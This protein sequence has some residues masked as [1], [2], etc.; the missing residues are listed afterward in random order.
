MKLSLQTPSAER[1]EESEVT[2]I[3]YLYYVKETAPPALPAQR[4][5]R[6]AYDS[7]SVFDWIYY[8]QSQHRRVRKGVMHLAL[9]F[10]H[11]FH[12]LAK[13]LPHRKYSLFVFRAKNLS[14]KKCLPSPSSL[15]LLSNLTSPLYLLTLPPFHLQFPKPP[16]LIILILYYLLLSIAK[17]FRFIT[18]FHCS[19]AIARQVTL[20]QLKHFISLT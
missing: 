1:K 20:L 6:G 4:A 19:S 7:G 16:L 18:L 5:T 11:P 12:F 3:N 15:P 8:I 9:L 10:T 2:L 17:R 14:S 13:T